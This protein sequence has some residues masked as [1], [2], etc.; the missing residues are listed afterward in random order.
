MVLLMAGERE[1]TTGLLSKGASFRLIVSGRVGEKEIERLIK[2]LELDKEILAD[3]DDGG[4]EE[5]LI[6]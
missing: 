3:V 4:S 1:L 5:G 6:G 2:K